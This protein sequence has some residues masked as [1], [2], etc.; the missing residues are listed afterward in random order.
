MRVMCSTKFTVIQFNIRVWAVVTCVFALAHSSVALASPSLFHSR[1]MH[2]HSISWCVSRWNQMRMSFPRTVASVVS[3]SACQ[4]T[5]AYSFRAGGSRCPG[6]TSSESWC[7]QRDIG[8]QCE[9]DA[10]GAYVCPTHGQSI[11]RVRWNA[12]VRSGKLVVQINGGRNDRAPLPRWAKRYPY[13]NGFIYPWATN[14]RLRSGLSVIGR[15]HGGCIAHG[16]EE[17]S[18]SQAL[19]CLTSRDRAYDPCFRAPEDA[20]RIACDLAPGDT[21]L[22]LLIDRR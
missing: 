4:V 5:V 17:S 9:L 10:Y 6:G 14:S 21:K 12:I 2:T 13:S 3:S 1:G 20:N 8:F 15:A 16:S 7:I 18:A 22:V 19:R 11:G